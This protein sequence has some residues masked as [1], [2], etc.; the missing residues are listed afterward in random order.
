ML[1]TVDWIDENHLLYGNVLGVQYVFADSLDYDC[2]A[3]AISELILR[4]PALSGKYNAKTHCVIASDKTISLVRNKNLQGSA[5]DYA[6][7]GFE[8]PGRD[9]FVKEPKRGDVLKGDAPLASFTLSEFSGGGCILGIA[10][11]HV[12][13]DAAGFHLLVK[14]L[15]QIYSSL[16]TNSV[17]PPGTIITQLDVFGFGSGKSKRQMLD[18]LKDEN[19]RRP[20]K[21]SGA[22]GSLVKSLIVRTLDRIGENTRVVLHFT[23]KDVQKLKKAVLGESNEEWISTNIALS[24]HFA[25]IMAKLMYGDKPKTRVG[26]GQLLDLRS[27]YFKTDHESQSAYVGNAIL[28]HTQK[29]QFAQGV[30][31]A[32]RGELARFFKHSVAKINPDFLSRRLNLISDCLQHGYS[33]PGLEFKDPIIALNNQSKMPVYDLTFGDARLLRVIPQDVGDN[34]MFFP[35]PDGG[36]EIYIRDILNPKRQEMLLTPEWQNLIFDF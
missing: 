26:F 35:T 1:H 4:F 14:N 36:V 23:P 25:H 8:A 27:R 9:I 17:T 20:V 28:I 30:Q 10:I 33:Y 6:K 15:A 3:Q 32:S 21:I 2:L 7:V 34:I 13:T 11:S 31:F 19:L 5:E 24:A 18:S 12:L 22:F 16:V 29:A